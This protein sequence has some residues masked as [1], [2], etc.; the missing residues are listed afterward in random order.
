[1]HANKLKSHKNMQKFPMLLFQHKNRILIYVKYNSIV[2]KKK[3]TGC[4]KLTCVATNFQTHLLCFFFFFFPVNPCRLSCSSQNP[5]PPFCFSA[6]SL[7]LLFFQLLPI[8]SLFLISC[9]SP[10]APC[11]HHDKSCLCHTSMQLYTWRNRSPTPGNE[12]LSWLRVWEKKTLAP[13][14][15]YTIVS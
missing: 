11:Y 9:K 5:D 12:M 8:F 1:M 15:V 4:R 2:W 6:L 7:I 14:G 13:R 3:S 10:L